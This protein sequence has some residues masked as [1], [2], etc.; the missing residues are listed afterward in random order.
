ML[1]D[2]VKARR[3]GDSLVVTLTR[4]AA[5]RSGLVSSLSPEQ[6]VRQSFTVDFEMAGDIGKD[7]AQG[8]DL[9]RPVPWYADVVLFALDPGGQP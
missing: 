7:A 1:H 9:Q 5:E 8:S 6:I 3:V 2:D 4:P